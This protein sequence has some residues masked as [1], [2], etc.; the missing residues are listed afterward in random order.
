MPTAT[1]VACF[2]GLESKRALRKPVIGIA[3]ASRLRTDVRRSHTAQ[4]STAPPFRRRLVAPSPSIISA[5]P[6]S[7]PCALQ[8]N[9]GIDEDT[10]TSHLSAV[11]RADGIT[12]LL[13]NGHAGDLATARAFNDRIYPLARAIYGTAPGGHANARLTTCLKLRGHIP[14]DEGC[15][16]GSCETKPFAPS[17]C[18]AIV[19]ALDSARCLDAADNAA[20]TAA[21]PE[22]PAAAPS[23]WPAP[24]A[25]SLALAA[26]ELPAPGRPPPRSGTAGRPT[27]HGPRTA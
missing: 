9:G 21:R 18:R 1:A 23:A 14:S 15:G 27:A 12:D 19:T 16:R 24:A 20:P 26:R 10:L 4:C 8:G 25:R 11:S 5:A 2:F 22:F 13:N 7:P 6:M 17:R 3:R